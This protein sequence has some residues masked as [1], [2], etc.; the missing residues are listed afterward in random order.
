LYKLKFIENKTLINVAITRAR[1]K[2]IL[3]GNSKTLCQSDLLK[4][5]IGKIGEKNS[6]IL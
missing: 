6:I 4:R 5:V 1:K 3:V 2:L